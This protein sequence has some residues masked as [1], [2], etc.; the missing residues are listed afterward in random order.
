MIRR[1]VAIVTAGTGKPSTSR[2]LA[3]RLAAATGRVLFDEGVQTDF[4]VIELRD[5]AHELANA[6]VT[7]FAAG[8]LRRA[9]DTVATA[10]GLIAVTPIYN[11]TYSGLFK[12]FFDVLDPGA[13][14]GKPVLVAA[15]AGTERH[16]LALDHSLRPLFAHL[17]AVVVP[18]GVF[19]ASVDWGAA[20]DGGEDGSLADRIDRAARQ[21]AASIAG[22]SPARVDDL[23]ADIVP[24]ADLL[25]DPG[26]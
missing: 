21:L 17:K 9:L 24:F 10:D 25:A 20:D 23:Y 26:R 15:T 4:E 6:M 8:R 19:A 2:L 3:D 1:S 18:T 14:A 7:G 16:S 12:C 22:A 5:L 11:A 13:L